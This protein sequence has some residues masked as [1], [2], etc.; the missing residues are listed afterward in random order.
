MHRLRPHH[1]LCIQFFIGKGYSEEFT[2][3]MKKLIAQLEDENCKVLIT[4]GCDDICEFCPNNNSGVCLSEDKVGQ[5]DKR[6]LSALGIE[7]EDILNW[8]QLRQLAFDNIIS[9]GRLNEICSD[10]CW[11]NI[12]VRISQ[13]CK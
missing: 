10:C 9:C 7:T 12:C 1:S 11:K 6:C 8:E 2:A 4:K 5:I 13:N 3:S